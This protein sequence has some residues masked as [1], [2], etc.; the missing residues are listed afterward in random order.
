MQV[1]IYIN[2]KKIVSLD[3]Y[4]IDGSLFPDKDNKTLEKIKNGQVDDTTANEQKSLWLQIEKFYGNNFKLPE[5]SQ[6]KASIEVSFAV[7]SYQIDY[8]NTKSIEQKN[9][10]GNNVISWNTMDNEIRGY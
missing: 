10:N 7:P 8:S 4:K 5:N 6:L 1:N 9:V 2:E 3:L